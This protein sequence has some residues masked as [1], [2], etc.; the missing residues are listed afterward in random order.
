MIE[1]E[2]WF[3]CEYMDS[4]SIACKVCR[5]TYCNGGSCPVCM[6]EFKEAAGMILNGTCPKREDMRVGCSRQ[7]MNELLGVK[8]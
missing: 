6:P 2:R 1:K 5:G 4:P 8:E 7:R 3:W